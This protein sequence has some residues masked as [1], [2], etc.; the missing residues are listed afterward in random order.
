VTTITV[1]RVVTG[2]SRHTTAGLP[3]AGTREASGAALMPG[4]Q[5]PPQSGGV[6]GFTNSPQ[7]GHWVFVRMMLFVLW[8]ALPLSA[9]VGHVFGLV[10]QRTSA[11]VVVPLSVLLAVL[12]IV[13][14]HP[15]DVIVR[16]GFIAGIVACVPY[17]VFRLSAVHV[18]H[19]MGD[20]IPALGT[21]ITGDTGAEAAAVGYLWRYLGDA[22]GAGVG[23]YVVAFTLGLHRWSHPRRIVL[24]A[25]VYAICP[26]WSG[27]IGLVTLAPRGQELMFRLTPATLLVT[28]IGHI[29]FGLVLGLAFVRAR[30]LGAHLPWA[31][32]SLRALRD[33]PAIA[34]VLRG[35][36]PK[37][38]PRR[39]VENPSM[40]LGDAA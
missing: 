12:T 22:A 17:D 36:A 18:G 10:S 15:S 35:L 6:A 5:G 29:I 8:S 31:P 39:L 11:M 40:P 13:A 23:F 25:V 7:G 28:L 32:I 26:V 9:I 4:V 3:T 30:H 19:L 21:W 34:V 38:T 2:T 1:P 24:A 20:F 33:T 37:V 14:P 27:L 16:Q